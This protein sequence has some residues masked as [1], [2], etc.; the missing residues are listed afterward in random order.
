MKPIL[1]L[2]ITAI[3]AVSCEPTAIRASFRD[4][5]SLVVHFKNNAGNEISKTVQTTDKNA[6]SRVID[7]IDAP[8][9]EQFQCGY[10]GKMFFYRD[11]KLY[12][13][14]DFNRMEGSCRIFSI[15][16]DGKLIHTRMNNEAM[17]F[18]NA[19][20]RGDIIY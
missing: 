15:V 5:D 20:E 10:D 14:A 12:Q 17:D 7:F 11:D 18:F 13:E 9:A 4:A 19:L 16:V 3:T 6:I 8:L 2:A 1:I